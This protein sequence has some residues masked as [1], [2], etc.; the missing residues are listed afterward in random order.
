MKESDNYETDPWLMQLFEGW[1]DPCPFR[2]IEND[3]YTNGLLEPWPGRSFVNPPYSDVMPWVEKA[4]VEARAGNTVV[5]LMKH[6]SST[7]WYRKL[8]EEGARFLPIFGR[9]KFRTGGS[10]SFPSV[11]VVLPHA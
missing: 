10:A 6:D 1:H 5:M 7:A 9:L 11:L 2:S 3:G 8:H 4:I